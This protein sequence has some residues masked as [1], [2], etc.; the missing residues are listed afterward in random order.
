[1]LTYP[2][3]ESTEK[4]KTKGN[5]YLQKLKSLPRLDKINYKYTMA[6][7]FSGGGG[8]DLGLTL[9]GFEPRFSSDVEAQHC[10]TLSY[11]F[12][13]EA[14]KQADVND[15]TGN[16]I[17]N[18]SKMK[19]I[20]LLAGGPPCQAFSI[21]GQRGSFNDPRGKLVFEYARI[22]KE[23]KPRVF[24]FENVP[25]ILNVN[26]G[27]D[28]Q[29]LLGFFSSETR[30]KLFYNILNAADFGIPQIRRRVFIVGF[31]DSN[32][33]F[34]FPTPTH[35]DLNKMTSMFDKTANLPSW[36]AAKL[37]LENV[38][39]LPNHRIRPH[40]TRVKN[41]YV[42]VAQGTRDKVDRTDR[43][44]PDLPSG[45]VLVG[46]RAGGGRPFIHPYEPRHLTVREAARLQSFPDW[47]V[48]QNSETWQY[49]A[50]G[51]A[52]P[53]LMAKAVGEAILKSLQ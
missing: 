47:Y 33:E 21:L 6:S 14:V 26:K 23:L 35:Q 17:K 15:L 45:T 30:Y 37:A 19:S 4:V 39:G 34:S 53:P 20:D 9:A 11:N 25:G 46:S 41:R 12:R 42:K 24:V 10:E 31:R 1:M 8:L 3:L 48:F 52:V 29:E 13:N 50:V 43:I 40:G 32:T 28:W 51:N 16:E 2:I 5:V 44:H 36:L 49:R 7:L 22:V 18:L 27:Q 38:D